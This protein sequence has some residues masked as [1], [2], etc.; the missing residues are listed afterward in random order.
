MTGM[1]TRCTTLVT[2][3][4]LV[5]SCS[6]SK[7]DPPTTSLAVDTGSTGTVSIPTESDCADGIDDDADGLVDCEDGDCFAVCIEDC[8]DDAD[9]DAD[10]L[11]DCADDDCMA[12]PQ[13]TPDVRVLGGRLTMNGFGTFEYLHGFFDQSVEQRHVTLFDVYGEVRAFSPSGAVTST[14]TWLFATAVFDHDESHRYTWASTG[15]AFDSQS[16]GEVYRTGFQLDPA[17]AA[18]STSGFLPLRLMFHDNRAVL[19]VPGATAGRYDPGEIWYDGPVVTSWVNRDYWQDN[20]ENWGHDRTSFL[21]MS[22]IS[23]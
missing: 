21:S 3:A 11:V 7:T 4:V 1:W 17:C 6:E 15:D 14:C 20:F 12:E 19:P 8:S 18:F 5:A 10:G 13:C 22:P 16:I 9:N 2:A 23:R